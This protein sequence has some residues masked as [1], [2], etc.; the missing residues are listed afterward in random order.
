MPRAGKSAGAHCPR[1]ACAWVREAHVNHSRQGD[2]GSVMFS[3]VEELWLK[4]RGRGSMLT[5]RLQELT[6]I[7]EVVIELDSELA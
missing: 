5:R 1:R 7:K 3:R 2:S 4:G 6:S